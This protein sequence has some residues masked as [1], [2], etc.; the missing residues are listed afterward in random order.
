KD[1][2][3]A[4]RSSVQPSENAKKPRKSGTRRSP[5]R[6]RRAPRNRSAAKVANGQGESSDNF[7][8]TSYSPEDDQSH[9]PAAEEKG[10]G[11]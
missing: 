2:S 9:S 11:S 4:R 3:E 7:S 10:E 6:N 5:I 8:E 1:A